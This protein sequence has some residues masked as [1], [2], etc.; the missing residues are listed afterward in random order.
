MVA[1]RS[2]NGLIL[3]KLMKAGTRL[4][5]YVEGK[6]FYGI[7]TGLNK[8]FVIDEATKDRLIAEDPKSAKIIK[9]FLAGREIKKYIE[10]KPHQYIILFEKGWTNKN[11]GN[12]RNKWIWLKENYPS[13]A[14]HLEP[15]TRE[16]EKRCDKGDYWWELRACDYYEEFE[17]PK[18]ILPDISLT[19]NISL[20]K[21]KKCYCVNTAYIIVN[22]E[23]YLL[24]VLNSKLTNFIYS[25]ISSKYRGGY[26]RF[27]YQY[28][29]QLPIHKIDFSNPKERVV[30]D[31]IECLVEQ[32]IGMNKK[33]DDSRLAAEKET[34]HRRIGAIDK[35]INMLVY[36]LY[37]LTEDEIKIIET[38]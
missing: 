26:L 33:L 22:S 12:A 23:L 17:K 21:D 20:D 34:A 10:L 11:S 29:I 16:G 13:I 15:F 25:K 8:A 14:N 38:V 37:G 24:G 31:K 4:G 1:F 36:Q 30:H 32:M 7:K 5:E 19:S 2:K 6:I 18:M 27:I 28:L 35:E 3:D 9:P